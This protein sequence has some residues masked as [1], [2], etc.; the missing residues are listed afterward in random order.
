MIEYNPLM[1]SSEQSDF[2]NIKR[3]KIMSDAGNSSS[4]SRIETI[5]RWLRSKLWKALPRY[6]EEIQ[7]SNDFKLTTRFFFD[8]YTLTH[9]WCFWSIL[10]RRVK[11][12][13]QDSRIEIENGTIN[14][15]GRNR[16]DLEKDDKINTC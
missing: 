6:N 15:R 14:N 8:Y 13:S 10:T 7:L 5:F 9:V 1:F 11:Y 4:E 3:R 16:Q 2:Y 12:H